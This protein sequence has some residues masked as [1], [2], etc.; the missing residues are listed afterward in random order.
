[1]AI[2]PDEV[3]SVFDFNKYAN[4]TRSFITNNFTFTNGEA[5]EYLTL[6]ATG[7]TQ[8]MT[9]IIK[10]CINRQ[11]NLKI[12]YY[13]SLEPNKYIYVP[14]YTITQFGC[15]SQTLQL[16][17][18]VDT[19]GEIFIDL[20]NFNINNFIRI[21]VNNEDGKTI[22]CILTSTLEKAMELSQ[23]LRANKSIDVVMHSVVN[24]ASGVRYFKL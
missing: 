2:S 15:M 10:E 4:I 20:T 23:Y 14:Q 21:R 12:L 7:L 1:M 3:I 22:A 6:Y 19:N 13:K 16:M 17:S 5:N 18:L 9:A 24:S 11:V 8:C